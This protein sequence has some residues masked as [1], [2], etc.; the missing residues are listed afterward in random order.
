MPGWDLDTFASVSTALAVF[1]ALVFGIVQIRHQ[2]QRRREELALD[3]MHAALVPDV[4]AAVEIVLELPEG[5]GEA[6]LAGQPDVR[7]AIAV[8]AFNLEAIGWMVQRRMVDLHDVDDLMGGITRALWRKVAPLAAE[9]R[10][11]GRAN[12]F[13]WLQWLAE[14]MEQDPSPGKAAGAHVTHA[15]W[16]R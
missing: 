3:A 2:N 10:A 11:T 7:R 1:S 12:E 14:R 6:D 15:A 5:L 4:L 9:R 16:R 13:E 8:V